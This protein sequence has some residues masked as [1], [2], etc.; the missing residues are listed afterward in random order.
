MINLISINYSFVNNL[1]K[2]YLKKNYCYK[3]ILKKFEIVLN[4]MKF[5][6]Y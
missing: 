1:Q 5:L 4:K 2:I 6:L 3:K